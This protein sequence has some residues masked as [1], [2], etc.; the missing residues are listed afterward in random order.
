MHSVVVCELNGWEEIGV[1][2]ENNDSV[3]LVR[4][5]GFNDTHRE[6]YVYTLM[7]SLSF[8]SPLHHHYPATWGTTSEILFSV[9]V[10]IVCLFQK[11]LH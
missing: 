2:G 3:D 10:C 5:G 6:R 7:S 9:P 11:S 1:V 4:E 8:R